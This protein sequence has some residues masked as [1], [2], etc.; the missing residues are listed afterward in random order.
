MG[1]GDGDGYESDFEITDKDY[2]TI[3]ALLK[4]CIEPDEDSD[5]EFDI[6]GQW[7]TEDILC[8]KAPELYERL[9]KMTSDETTESLIENA[10]DYFDEEEEGCTFEEYMNA[11]YSWGFRITDEWINKVINEKMK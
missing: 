1:K 5:G 3:V 4:E 2:A 11:G 10:K 9:E 6:D 7:F 8:K